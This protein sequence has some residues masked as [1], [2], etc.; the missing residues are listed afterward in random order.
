MR[1]AVSTVEPFTLDGHA[2]RDVSLT[3]SPDGTLR[4][5][6][7]IDG[8]PCRKFFKKNS[9]TAKAILLKGGVYMPADEKKRL[10]ALL[11]PEK[12]PEENISVRRRY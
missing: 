5:D 8:K 11:L 6:A 12:K 10:V 3:R 1:K 9:G 2:V 7:K 4:L